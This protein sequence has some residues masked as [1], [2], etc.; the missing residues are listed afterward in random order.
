MN[1]SRYL[2]VKIRVHPA[3]HLCFVEIQ[4]AAHSQTQSDRIRLDP[5]ES[6]PIKV[7]KI[8][9]TQGAERS[10]SIPHA[11]RLSFRLSTINHPLSTPQ[12]QSRLLKANQGK[13]F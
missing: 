6:D 11:Q 5:T 4:H 8:R 3:V 10:T 12:L 2:S 1:P 13:K 9:S 7:K